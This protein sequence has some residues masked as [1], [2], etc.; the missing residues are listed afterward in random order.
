MSGAMSY[1]RSSRAGRAVSAAIVVGILAT[2]M[3]GCNGSD[4]AEAADGPPTVSVSPENI[5]IVASERLETGPSISGDLTPEKS[6]SI[7]AEVGGSVI[8]TY[9]EDGQRVA[10]GT[11]LAKIDDTGIQDSYLSARSAL[12][13]AQSAADVAKREEERAVSLAAA[14]AIA[15]R[16]VENARRANIA[17]QA[18]LADARARLSLAEKQVQNTNVTAPFDGI[19]SDRQVS[20]GDV[21]QP[22]SPMFT[23]V[24]PTTMRLEAA[25]SAEQL[26]SIRIGRPV[27]FTVSGYPGRTFAGAITRVS[28]TVD[29]ATRQVRIFASIPNAGQ[30]LVGGLFAEGRIAA[31]SH[32]GPV[33]PEDAIDERAT[34]PAVMRIRNGA[35]EH[36]QVAIGIRDPATERVEI[37]AGVS[38]GDTLLVGPARS[39]TVN[40]PVRVTTRDSGESR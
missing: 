38:V 19:V 27:T 39:I 18:Q 31:E 36:V 21:V 28:P 24:D 4:Q 15:D 35:V 12:T 1:V 29:P 11:R 22:G 34:V 26:A 33:A 9:V 6:A 2:T 40:T 14:G 10:R 13:A 32:V 37:V 8:A 20:A 7:R 25:V 30:T 5:H 16:D 17:A 3:V 23:V